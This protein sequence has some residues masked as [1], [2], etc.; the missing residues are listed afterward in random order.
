MWNTIPSWF[1]HDQYIVYD[2]CWS[3]KRLDPL[4]SGLCQNICKSNSSKVV[5]GEN[6]WFLT[7]SSV[8]V[9]SSSTINLGEFWSPVDCLIVICF[10]SCMEFRGPTMTYLLGPWRARRR[11]NSARLARHFRSSV[12]VC[13]QKVNAQRKQI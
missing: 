9:F 12:R 11:M 3:P 13:L 8:L 4:D 2:C 7:W 6:L 10:K 1:S 5:F